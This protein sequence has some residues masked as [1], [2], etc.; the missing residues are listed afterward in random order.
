MVAATAID[1]IRFDYAF[2][3]VNDLRVETEED[4]KTGQYKPTA[5]IVNDES[6]RPSQRFWTSLFA[7]YGFNKSFFKYFGYDEVFDRIAQVEQAD[8]LR[9]CIERRPGNNSEI[10]TLMAVSNPTKPIV[11]HEELMESLR[12]YNG[13]SIDYVDGEVYSTH[14]P[15][16]GAANFDIC[17]D[18]F[19]NRFVMA[20]PIDG[21]GTPNF[22]L[23]L[24]RQVCSNGMIGYAKAFRSTL[25]LGKGADDV[26]PT[27]TRALDGFG[28]DEG[29]AALRQR[30]ESATES[31]CSVFESTSLYK[32]IT[33]LHASK[34]LAGVDKRLEKGKSITDWMDDAIHAGRTVVEDEDEVGGVGSPI[35]TAYHRMTGDTNHLYGLANLDALSAK[36]QRAL[37]VNCTVYDALN[38]AT[39]VAT[40]YA[41]PD[42][43]RQLNAWCGSLISAE[44][45]MEG[46]KQ[47][48]DD[49]ADFHIEAKVKERLTGSEYSG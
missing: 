19:S 16:V 48:F 1:D 20:T 23:S 12:Q 49:F 41:I 31:W 40:H 28:N 18:V 35:L 15:R 27:I 43:A 39:E 42:G 5:I 13:Q 46:T 4:P 10:S 25:N 11:Q 7:R 24:M 3:P 36:R 29:F 21:Y 47:K 33:K 26:M 37:P 22:Y 17:G 32:L 30:M 2:L 38:F 34:Q 9:L 45:D 44:Y 6:V 14:A 8:R